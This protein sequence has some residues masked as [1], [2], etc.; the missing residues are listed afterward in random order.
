[1]SAFTFY[2]TWG[3]KAT[4]AHEF[5]QKDWLKKFDPQEQNEEGVCIALA[6]LWL[7]RYKRKTQEPSPMWQGKSFKKLAA[8]DVKEVDTDQDEATGLIHQFQSSYDL[9]IEEFKKVQGDAEIREYYT[10]LA[11]LEAFLRSTMKAFNGGVASTAREGSY[12]VQGL[13]ADR[14][15]SLG[16]ELTNNGRYLLDSDGHAWGVIIDQSGWSEDSPGTYKFFDPN[17]GRATWVNNRPKFREF[18]SNYATNPV[19]CS[20][21]LTAAWNAPIR[22]AVCDI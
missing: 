1:M 2:A 19:F 5:V 7:S 21:S 13:P 8:Y 3:Y 4:K 10:K 20:T 18:L 22:W 14:R 9:V 16:T 12:G 6:T 11:S 15:G 17:W